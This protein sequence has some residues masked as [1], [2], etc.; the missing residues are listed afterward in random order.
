MRSH[1]GGFWCGLDPVYLRKPLAHEWDQ[2]HSGKAKWISWEMDHPSFLSGF[3][4][5]FPEPVIFQ[6]QNIFSCSSNAERSVLVFRSLLFPCAVE[7]CVSS[8]SF[9]LWPLAP[10]AACLPATA[11]SCL[12]FVFSRTDAF[13]SF[14]R[15]NTWDFFLWLLLQEPA[16][17]CLF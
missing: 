5:R 2:L 1:S 14:S 17:V 10:G 3:S 16:P 12:E 9:S 6:A 11:L 8:W 7:P 15:L 13:F 4:P